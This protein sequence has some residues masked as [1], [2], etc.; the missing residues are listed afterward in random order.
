MAENVSWDKKKIVFKTLTGHNSV[1]WTISK[2]IEY[3][4]Q[5]ISSFVRTDGRTDGRKEFWIELENNL[6]KVKKVKKSKK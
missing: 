4:F 1:A 6:K 2:K 3:K 5:D